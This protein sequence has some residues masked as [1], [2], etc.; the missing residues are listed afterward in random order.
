M[1]CRAGPKLFKKPSSKS[2][3]QVII[4]ALSSCCLAGAVNNQVKHQVL[5]VSECVRACVCGCKQ[6]VRA[7]VSSLL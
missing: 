5:E 2:N 4:Q 7:I 3:K 1:L 6:Q